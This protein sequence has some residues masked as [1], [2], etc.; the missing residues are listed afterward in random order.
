MQLTARRVRARSEPRMLAG[1]SGGGAPLA[2]FFFGGDLNSPS[3][4]FSDLQFATHQGG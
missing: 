3:P 2:I 1:G 4:S